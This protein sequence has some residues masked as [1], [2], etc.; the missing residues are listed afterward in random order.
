MI[1]N[2]KDAFVFVA[3][4]SGITPI[5]VMMRN[6]KL[7]GH[8]QFKLIYCTRDP[9]STAFFDELQAQNLRPM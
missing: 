7:Q 2:P 8:Q 3:G 1:V 4:D 9:A 6:L 5:L